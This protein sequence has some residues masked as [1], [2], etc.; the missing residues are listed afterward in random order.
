MG[1]VGWLV[2]FLIYFGIFICSKL[3]FITFPLDRLRIFKLSRQINVVLKR[4]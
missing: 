2:V 1:Y 4:A 3:F